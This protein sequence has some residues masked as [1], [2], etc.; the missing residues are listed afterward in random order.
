MAMMTLKISLGIFFARIVV[1]QWQV[2]LIYATV[3]TN[4]FS[5]IAAFFYCLFRCGSNIDNYVSQQLTLQC[6]PRTLDRFMAYQAAGITTLTDIVF[7]TLPVFILWNANMSRRS[8]TSVG[9]ILCLAALY[10]I[11]PTPTATTTPP[12]TSL[13]LT[14]QTAA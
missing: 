9:F 5:S 2:R 6:T 13:I 8:K 3:G 7:V 4:I 12:L 10:V 14:R 1:Q 11:P